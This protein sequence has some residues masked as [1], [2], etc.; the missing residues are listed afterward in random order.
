[1]GFLAHANGLNRMV[2]MLSRPS[3]AEK[4]KPMPSGSGLSPLAPSFTPGSS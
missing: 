4:H 3:S 1:M 2:N